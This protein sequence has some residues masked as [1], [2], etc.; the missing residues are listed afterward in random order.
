MHRPISPE[1]FAEDEPSLKQISLE[2]ESCILY[3]EPG[4]HWSS[5][6]LN[7]A[8]ISGERKCRL[9]A[10]QILSNSIQGMPL[11]WLVFGVAGID[12]GLRQAISGG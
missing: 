5:M 3:F 8:S 7:R 2:L 1:A 11:D 12:P 6:T 9:Q 10:G 4:P